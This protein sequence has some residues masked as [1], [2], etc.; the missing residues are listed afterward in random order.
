MLFPLKWDVLDTSVEAKAGTAYELD[1]EIT[2]HFL[3]N[4]EALNKMGIKY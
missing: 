1:V 2:S 3:D 4:Q